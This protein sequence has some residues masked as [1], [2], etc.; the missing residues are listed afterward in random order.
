MMGERI[1][2]T[3]R[4]GEQKQKRRAADHRINKHQQ[5]TSHYH[6]DAGGRMEVEY[7]FDER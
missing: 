5:G 4:G 7:A 1:K 6:D 3:E 2:K